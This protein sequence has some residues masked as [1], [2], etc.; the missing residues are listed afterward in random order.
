[1]SYMEHNTLLLIK[2]NI[3]AKNKIGEILKIIEDH[4]FII[5]RLKMFRMSEKIASEF[6][7]EH[8]GKSFYGRLVEFM[9]SGTTVGAVLHRNNAVQML[10]E[11]IGNTDH[12]KAHPGTI[13]FLYGETITRNAVHASDSIEHAERE[14]KLIFPDFTFHSD[15]NIKVE[16]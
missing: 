14:I 4:G 9:M 3:T 1:M 6:Y 13:R 16:T 15:N 5:D 11:L 10:R 12:Q 2:P 7:Q 8:K